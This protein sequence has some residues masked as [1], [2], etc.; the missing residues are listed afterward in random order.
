MKFN[1]KENTLKSLKKI[2]AHR[3][4]NCSMKESQLDYSWEKLRREQKTIYSTTYKQKFLCIARSLDVALTK[5]NNVSRKQFWNL[6]VVNFNKKLISK[7]A[8]IS[9]ENENSSESKNIEWLKFKR[10][11]S[12]MLSTYIYINHFLSLLS[13]IWNQESIHFAVT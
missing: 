13:G 3:N 4:K 8:N 9:I 1:F 12:I 11:C 7:T 6:W 10:K 2:H 5:S